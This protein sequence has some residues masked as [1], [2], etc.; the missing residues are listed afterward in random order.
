MAA[1]STESDSGCQTTVTI[2][3]FGEIWEPLS[4]W[5]G[6]NSALYRSFDDLDGLVL[7][8]GNERVD[9]ITLVSGKVNHF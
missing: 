4:G 9:S 2:L 7:M 1:E 5:T 6:P 3:D 8:E